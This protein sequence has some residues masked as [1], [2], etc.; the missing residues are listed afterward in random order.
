M[1]LHDNPHVRQR[2]LAVRAGSPDEA[3][4]IVETDLVLDAAAEG[5][6]ATAI[7]ILNQE[8]AEELR[9]LKVDKIEIVPIVPGG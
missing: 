1:A 2:Q 3:V 9:D 8:I 7:E 6:D 4:F 5:Y